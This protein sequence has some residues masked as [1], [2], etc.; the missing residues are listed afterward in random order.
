[1]NKR[2]VLFIILGIGLLVTGGLGVKMLV[3]DKQNASSAIRV[4]AFPKAEVYINGQRVGQTPYSNEHMKPGSYVLKLVTAPGTPGSFIPWEEQVKLVDGGLTYVSQDLAGSADFSAG[5]TLWLSK[6]MTDRAELTVVSEP[7]DGE[8][9]IDKLDKGKTSLLISDLEPG[10]HEIVVSRPGY[11]DQVIH[12]MLVAGY[13]LNVVV[14]LGRMVVRQNEGQNQA[15]PSAVVTAQIQ[16]SVAG[17]ESPYVIIKDTP[18]GFLR[19]RKEASVTSVQIDEV[20]PGGKY[21]LVSE[22]N[23]WV[24]LRQA[25]SSAN[26][27]W[28]SGDFV[29]I[30]R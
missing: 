1:M 23:G 14:K 8:V 7:D 24:L 10:N 20:K 15:S 19:V 25:S 28:V 2:A 11:A 29:T 26:L 6:L 30:Y 22:T 9:N 21:P 5:Q 16:K 3:L 13:R 27:G 17:A 12:G 4:D 18:T